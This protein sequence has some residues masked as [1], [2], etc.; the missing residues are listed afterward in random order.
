MRRCIT[1]SP[2]SSSP[3]IRVCKQARAILELCVRADK[4]AVCACMPGDQRTLCERARAHT[5]ADTHNCAR[6]RAHTHSHSLQKARKSRSSTSPTEGTADKAARGQAR[7]ASMAAQIRRHNGEQCSA[8]DSISCVSVQPASPWSRAEGVEAV[9][10][11]WPLSAA[12]HTIFFAIHRSSSRD[13]SFTQRIKGEGVCLQSG[14]SNRGI[15]QESDK[16]RGV[17]QQAWTYK[18]PREI[19][20]THGRRASISLLQWSRVRIWHRCGWSVCLHFHNNP[21][22]PSPISQLSRSPCA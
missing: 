9:D 1:F 18:Q 13:S 7:G 16:R 3:H 4:I 14:G 20:T 2:L 11:Y 6:A 17:R 22:N 19:R 5:H 15:E 21:L 10:R 12:L 8:R